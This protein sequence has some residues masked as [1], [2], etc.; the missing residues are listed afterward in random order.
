[1]K[2]VLFIGAL[3]GVWLPAQSVS[4]PAAHDIALSTSA[5]KPPPPLPRV[6]AQPMDAAPQHWKMNR[7]SRR[8]LLQSAI[9]GDSDFIFPAP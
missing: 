2:A 7:S 1:M 3:S 6:A 8:S 4:S 9:D 5:L